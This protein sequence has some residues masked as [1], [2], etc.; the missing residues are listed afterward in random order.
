MN[1]KV[2]VHEDGSV[3]VMNS[4]LALRDDGRVDCYSSVGYRILDLS[5][6][7]EDI[8]R[9]VKQQKTEGA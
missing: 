5:S 8:Q 1:D 9:L 7:P 4:T 3:E 6:L 2:K